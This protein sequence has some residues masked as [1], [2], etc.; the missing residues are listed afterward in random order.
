MLHIAALLHP[1]VK[2]ERIFGFAEPKSANTILKMYKEL[3]PSR[4]FADQ[5]PE[6]EEDDSVVEEKDRAEEL[7]KWLTGKEWTR[8]KDSL[9]EVGDYLVEHEKAG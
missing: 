8:M 9:K 2:N 4:E 3:Y 1:D 5:D 6:E 7:L